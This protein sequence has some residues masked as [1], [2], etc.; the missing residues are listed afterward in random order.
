ME[1]GDVIFVLKQK[2]HDRFEREGDDLLITVTITLAEALCGFSKVLITHLDGR[3]LVISQP[4][5]EVI[6][7][8]VVKCIANE[9]MPHYKRSDE[10]GNLYVK[11][12]V[13]FP[14][15]MWAS[16]DKLQVC[17]ECVYRFKSVYC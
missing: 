10:Q 15:S 14:A 9:G 11:F 13:E 7:P 16:P 5:G 4:S 1:T 17:F 3:G 8:G 2:E 12:N 6:T